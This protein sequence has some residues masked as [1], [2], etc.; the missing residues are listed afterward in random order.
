MRFGQSQRIDHLSDVTGKDGKPGQ[1]QLLVQK[2][3]I[4]GCIVNDDL[5]GPLYECQELAGNFSKYGLVDQKFGRDAVHRLSTSVNG[6]LRVDVQVQVPA[7]GLTI[8]KFHAA[9]FNDAMPLGD[10]Q[11]SGFGVENDLAHIRVFNG[12]LWRD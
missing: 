12:F 6:A 2:T 9:N 1:L 5:I 3:S 7:G 4:E 10:F 8:D 11:S